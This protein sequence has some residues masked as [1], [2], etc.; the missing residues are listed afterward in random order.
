MLF[1]FLFQK[2]ALVSIIIF[3]FFDENFN[4]VFKTIF[5]IFK[6]F[7]FCHSRKEFKVDLV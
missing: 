3:K 7:N 6:T 4:L 1:N 5:W 2:E